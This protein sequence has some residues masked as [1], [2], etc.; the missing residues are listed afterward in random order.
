MTKVKKTEEE[1]EIEKEVSVEI[2]DNKKFGKA[3]FTQYI[4][5]QC[6]RQLFLKLGKDNSRWIA[7]FREITKQTV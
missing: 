4:D 1:I 7:P 5:T 3:V 6:L 2:E